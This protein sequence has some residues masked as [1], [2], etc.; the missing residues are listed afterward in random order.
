MTYLCSVTDSDMMLITVLLVILCKAVYSE[1]H[2]QSPSIQH[3]ITTT[4]CVDG[5]HVTINMLADE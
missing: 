1:E 3:F 5:D 2:G 4:S